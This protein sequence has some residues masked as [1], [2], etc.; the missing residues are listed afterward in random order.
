VNPPL[1]RAPQSDETSER[2]RKRQKKIGK[3]V[4]AALA[5]RERAAAE[6]D[7]AER[8]SEGPKDEALEYLEH[9]ESTG[10]GQAW[11]LDPLRDPMPAGAPKLGGVVA[12]L[13]RRRLLSVNPDSLGSPPMVKRIRFESTNGRAVLRLFS[14]VLA[15]ARFLAATFFD[16]LIRRDT[17]TRRAVR[18]RETL[19]RMG[20]T[21]IKLGQQLSLR[22]DVV[23]Y[24]YTS[25]LSK[26]LDKV[27]AF[28]FAEA[29]AVI[30]RAHGRP[31]EET[32]AV[33]DPE[34]I[35][36]ASL[37]CVYQAVRQDG[38]RVA[39]KVRRPGIGDAL[40]V[41]LRVLGWLMTFAEG[42]TLLR[43]GMT[44][45]L[46]T[47]LRSMLMEELDF[48]REARYTYLFRRRAE[49][50]R[51]EYITA[52][53]VHFDLS[54]EEVLVTEFV[55]GIFM[56]EL[57]SAIDRGDDEAIELIKEAGI[58]PKVVAYR[59][60]EAFN[61]ETMESL[62]FHADPHPG[63]IILRPGSLLVFIDFGSCGRFPTKTKNAWKMLHGYLLDEDVQG[64]TRAAISVLEPLPHIDFES[65]TKE[66]ESLFWDWLYAMQDKH[67]E[68]W[69]KASGSIWMRFVGIVRRYEVPVNLDTIRLFRATFLYDTTAYRLFRELKMDDEYRRWSKRAGK[70]AKKRLSKQVRRRWARGLPSSDF[71]QIE[72]MTR[73]GR[74]LLQRVQHE[75][76]KP[77]HQFQQMLGKVGYVVSFGLKL[78]A[79]ALLLHLVIVSVL[80]VIGL[81]TGTTTNVGDAFR[82]VVSAKWYQ[83]GVAAIGFILLRRLIKRIQDVDV[84]K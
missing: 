23:P 13:P 11:L 21:F 1:E 2:R 51:Q 41:D 81:V 67:S 7:A 26:M 74:Q 18:L 68:W 48:R 61:F 5:R 16:I 40:A 55:S 22:A 54:N 19:Q 9:L 35:G 27:P 78:T 17:V 8:A 10:L 34:P 83:I 6:R 56:W 44:R 72:D 14:W 79:V 15:I 37:A 46:R 38:R 82:Q 65:F 60:C 33:F 66:A 63:N 39:V 62:L 58:D 70:R 75:L 77:R 43:A 64:M 25:E 47:E 59:M 28:P 42:T 52:P 29:R 80:Y 69:E 20:P 76:D 31:L 71:L 36:S 49:K 24:E 32:F 84:E 73:L 53:Y 12:S 45:H 57:L 50:K 4:K 30:E 3:A